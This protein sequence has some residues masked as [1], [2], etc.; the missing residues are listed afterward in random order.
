M[1]NSTVKKFLGLLSVK[2][3]KSIRTISLESGIDENQLQLRFRGLKEQG[4][5]EW[6][7]VKAPSRGNGIKFKVYRISVFGEQYMNFISTIG[8]N[9]IEVF[10]ELLTAILKGTVRIKELARL[11]ECTREYIRMKLLQLEKM[12]YVHRSLPTTGDGYPSS[13]F[14]ITSRG[15]QFLKQVKELEASGLSIDV[16]HPKVL[17]SLEKSRLIAQWKINNRSMCNNI[18]T[19]DSFEVRTQ[20]TKSNPRELHNIGERN[21]WWHPNNF[22]NPHLDGDGL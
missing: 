5:L 21:H 6:S 4:L 7:D 9:S 20:N 8:D 18:S 2:D 15:H 12:G 22:N 14:L 17:N 13:E 11:G 1:N 10:Q 19:T 16:S 3:W